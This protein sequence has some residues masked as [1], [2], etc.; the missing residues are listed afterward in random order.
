MIG[1]NRKRRFLGRKPRDQV[2]R[3]ES[4]GEFAGEA[5]DLEHDP[6]DGGIAHGAQDLRL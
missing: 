6:L 5:V 2:R 3:L 1:E 4:A